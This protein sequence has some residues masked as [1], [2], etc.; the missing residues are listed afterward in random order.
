[1]RS[2]P[3]WCVGL[4][5]A[6]LL[7]P[8]AAFGLVVFEEKFDSDLPNFA[9]YSDWNRSYCSDNWRTDLNG[10]VIAGRDDSC[11]QCGC[12]FLVQGSSQTDCI[13]SDPMD[14]HIQNG[15]VYWQNYVYSVRFRNS[16]DD[17]MGV[18][19][20][21][22]DSTTFYLFLLSRDTAPAAA[23]G[24]DEIFSGAAL[25]RVRSNAAPEYLAKIPGVTYA[26]NT[27][28]GIEVA[29]QYN[30]IIIRFDADG[31]GAFAADEKIVDLFDVPAKTIPNGRIGL[32]AYQN[33]VQNDGAEVP[34]PCAGKGC[35]FDDV[36]VD[37][38]PP[39]SGNCG[40]V[41]WEGFCDGNTLKFC[42]AT[43]K[44]QVEP[45]SSNTC[46]RWVASGAF[47]S[48]VPPTQCGASCKDA[49][50]QG[51][52]GCSANLDAKWVCGSGDADA[53]KEPQFTA[54]PGGSICNPKTGVCQAVCV[55]QCAELECGPDGCGG[56]CG[57]CGEGMECKSGKCEAPVQGQFGDPCAG[58]DD[59][60]NKMCIEAPGG[61]KLCSKACAGA[62]GCPD[63]FEC[64]DVLYN[65]NKVLACVPTG[66]CTPQCQGK[67]CG[68]DGCGGQCGECPDGFE[69]VAGL[70]KALDGAT[71]QTAGE[72]AGG[73][74]IPFQTGL[75]CSGPCVSDSECP[76][77]WSCA[78][79]ISASM[80]SICAPKGTMVAHKLCKE[81]ASCV[82]GC[83]P[84]NPACVANCFFLGSKQAQADYAGLWVCSEPA[85]FAACGTDSDCLLQCI[86]DKCFQEYA[87]CYPGTTTCK[88]ALDC[89]AG[90]SSSPTCSAKCWDEALPS[91]K[92]QIKAL[93]DCLGLFC[94]DESPPNC[95][96][97]AVT[98]PY[99]E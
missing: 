33:G 99:A 30:H 76:D 55:P 48:C 46:C 96:A 10:G 26:L 38:L 71:C 28:H 77:T 81:V 5:V 23:S 73:L 59:C 39:T 4:C 42:D 63:G 75:K 68:G 49:C 18:V 67:Q 22:N 69:C 84:A 95:I 14:N 88:Q 65:G 9:S 61:K 89:M 35:W 13:S 62:G 31:D 51:D 86:L 19:F 15:N 70:C 44:L 21:Y 41:G 98:G 12:N 83:P 64:V 45:C 7:A 37:I 93:L 82:G 92:K 24:C 1:M 80:P 87:T 8:R 85:C 79:W 72:C 58:S 50:K 78:P 52:K 27:V 6:L 43:G 40:A 56:Q 94:N 32:Y 47:Y 3:W 97:Q 74:C 11:P 29:V 90:C 36:K 57:A 16:D 17:S 2:A 54:C 25:L 34:P 91:A 60:A 20:R 66:I 53:C